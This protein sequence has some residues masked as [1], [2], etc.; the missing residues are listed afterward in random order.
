MGA[1]PNETLRNIF[2]AVPCAV[3]NAEGPAKPIPY[4]EAAGVEG[5]KLVIPKVNNA[6]GS[7][8]GASSTSF[9]EYRKAREF[10][11]NYNKFL[12]KKHES[13]Q[14]LQQFKER[15]MTHAEEEAEKTRKR[16]ERRKKKKAKGRGKRPRSEA[17]GAPA[18]S[19]AA[20]DDDA[21]SIT[22]Q[23]ARELLGDVDG[24]DLKPLQSIV[25]G[26]SEQPAAAAASGQDTLPTAA[27]KARSDE[28]S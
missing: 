11:R 5:S 1:S 20:G 3:G 8:A 26:G 12:E 25:G 22:S 23:E 17:G 21:A 4:S 19:A 9:H 13:E 27:K 10:E 15:V 16:A 2:H 24:E 18:V 6:H 14:G 28:A 7:S